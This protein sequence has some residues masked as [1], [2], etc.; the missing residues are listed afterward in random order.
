MCCHMSASSPVF[1]SSWFGEP[2]HTLTSTYRCTGESSCSSNQSLY[3]LQVIVALSHSGHDVAS[4]LYIKPLL[5]VCSISE[6]AVLMGARGAA[7][8]VDAGQEQLQDFLGLIITLLHAINSEQADSR[9]VVDHPKVQ[10][11]LHAVVDGHSSMAVRLNA[12]ALMLCICCSEAGVN[13]KTHQQCRLEKL[14]AAQQP[15]YCDIVK[16][17]GRFDTVYKDIQTVLQVGTHAPSATAWLA[18]SCCFC[19]CRCE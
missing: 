19:L 17:E 18:K 6:S 12:T 7:A 11:A 15:S 10:H 13:V 9:H 2:V 8:D 16:Q 1:V 5:S 4:L 3:T 14:R